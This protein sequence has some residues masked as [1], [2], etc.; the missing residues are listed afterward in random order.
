MMLSRTVPAS[1]NAAC[2]GGEGAQ[3]KGPQAHVR[4]PLGWGHLLPQLGLYARHRRPPWRPPCTR[5][6]PTKSAH[7][8]H[9]SHLA[10]QAD[11]WTSDLLRQPEHGT[12][13]RGAHRPE[14]AGV[15]T[16]WRSGKARLRELR[17]S[18]DLPQ[19]VAPTTATRWPAGMSSSS[20]TR[21]GGSSGDHVKSPCTAIAVSPASATR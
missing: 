18:E 17:T 15:S 10:A 13:L 14:V 19:P 4:L 9:I 3:L 16:A 20:S 6:P 11:R 1:T 2:T 12:D 5:H 21:E 8:W 7:L